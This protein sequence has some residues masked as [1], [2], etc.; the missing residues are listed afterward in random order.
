VTSE[1][2]DMFTPFQIAHQRL[3]ILRRHRQLIA[4]LQ[5]VSAVAVVAEV[6]L[7]G[8]VSLDATVSPKNVD[9]L[10]GLRRIQSV[11]HSRSPPSMATAQ[12]TSPGFEAIRST[13][14]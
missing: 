10:S 1:D 8:I 2:A 4:V 3:T 9:A 12:P 5:V 14:R 6:R 13:G 11:T 7:A